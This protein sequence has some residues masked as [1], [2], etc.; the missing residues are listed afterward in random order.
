M[1]TKFLILFGGLVMSVFTLTRFTSTSHVNTQ[2]EEI[3]DAV[4]D[5]HEDY[6]YNFIALNEDDEAYTVTFQAVSEEVLKVFNLN[7]ETL[8]D[9]KFT[10]TYTHEVIIT[11]D[12]DGYEDEEE[13]NT[14]TKLEKL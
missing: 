14:I 7:E 10:I 2:D 9:T 6:G 11:K 12:S 1:K 8:I 4:Y 13:I 5:G 3:I